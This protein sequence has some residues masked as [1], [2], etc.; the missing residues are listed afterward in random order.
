MLVDKTDEFF[1]HV[2]LSMQQNIKDDNRKFYIEIYDRIS[3]LS[4]LITHSTGYRNILML[5]ETSNKLQNEIQALDSIAI[6]EM[7]D[8]FEGIK[9]ILRKKLVDVKLKIGKVKI[10]KN[11]EVYE[12]KLD[13]GN[14]ISKNALNL[15]REELMQL[16]IENKQI[17]ES[18]QYEE[19]RNKLL[20]I[21]KVQSA[22]NEQLIIQNERIDDVF[23]TTKET[24]KTFINLNKI[25]FNENGSAFKRFTY[26][27]ILVLTLLLSISHYRNR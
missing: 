12:E 23:E 2:N 17:I 7:D 22:I 3:E 13:R 21:N 8:V 16:E 6:K 24:K 27:F 14:L 11:T 15:N 20:N 25:N 10:S 4:R 1:R 9:Y 18:K 26:K 5:E 19:T